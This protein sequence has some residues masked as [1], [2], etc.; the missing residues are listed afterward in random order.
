VGR[1]SLIV[2]GVVLLLLAAGAALL[3]LFPPDPAPQRVERPV[4]LDRVAPPPRP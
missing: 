3:G 4:P 2:A 1:A